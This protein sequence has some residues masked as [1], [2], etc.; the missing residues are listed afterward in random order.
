MGTKILGIVGSLREQSHTRKL[1]EM[2]LEIVQSEGGEGRLLDLR[3]MPLPIFN[4]D[5]EEDDYAPNYSSIRNLVVWA[6]GFIIGSPDYHGSMS[7]GIKNF[8]DFFWS[9]FSGKLFGYIIASHE[10]GL[11]VQDQLRTA[12]RQCYGWSLPYGIGFN[13]DE[14]FDELFQLCNPRLAERVV[15]LANDLVV[16]GGLLHGQL[17]R[18]LAATPIPPGFA[19]RLAEG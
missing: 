3:E 16:Y 15:M 11:T 6:D 9:E 13:G 17:K 1:M 8:L 12:V 7:G 14:D 19:R 10:K 5:A 2:T 4:P 18:D